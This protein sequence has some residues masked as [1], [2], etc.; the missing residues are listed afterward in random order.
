MVKLD[1]IRPD[2]LF[3]MGELGDVM[4]DEDILEFIR[5]V[6]YKWMNRPYESF[7]GM[8]VYRGNNLMH[9]STISCTQGLDIV[10]NEDFNLREIYRVRLNL[11]VDPTLLPF[12]AIERLN[13]YPKALV[14][15]VAAINEALRYNV[16][17]QQSMS[18]RPLEPWMLSK[19]WW[20][21]NGIGNLPQTAI[22]RTA[23][24][25]RSRDTYTI[26]DRAWDHLQRGA[27]GMRT[28]QIH[29]V[30]VKQKD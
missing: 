30:L 1:T 17:L 11:V 8:N 19:L 24:T 20:I 4:I 27:G 23:D 28:V 13:R 6:E 16:D 14:K 5:E 25:G 2:S 22:G 3:N 18:L 15:I 9:P 21:L 10:P 7:L 29:N 26:P 12:A